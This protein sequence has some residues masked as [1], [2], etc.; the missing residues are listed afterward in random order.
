MFS[1]QHPAKDNVHSLLH[2]KENCKTKLQC[3]YC[4]F[5]HL[6]KFPFLL[7]SCGD[8]GILVTGYSCTAIRFTPHYENVKMATKLNAVED[9]DCGRGRREL[10]RGTTVCGQK[11]R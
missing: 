1:Y 11:Y 7:F 10:H 5:L 8:L 4:T 3:F 6:S 9:R 2:F